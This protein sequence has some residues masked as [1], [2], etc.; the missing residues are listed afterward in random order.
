MRILKTVMLSLLAAICAVAATVA[1]FHFAAVEETDDENAYVSSV[2][3]DEEVFVIELYNEVPL[4][5]M[6]GQI[7]M[8]DSSMREQGAAFA[9][10]STLADSELIVGNVDPRGG[11]AVNLADVIMFSKFIRGELSAAELAIFDI[12]AADIRNTGLNPTNVDLLLLVE[13]F[14]NPEVTSSI[15]Y[16]IGTNRPRNPDR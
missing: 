5:N 13:W 1:V 11:D 3:P 2:V 9:T 4:T 6:E 10:L 7:D 16:P 8:S 15:D 14:S 12:D